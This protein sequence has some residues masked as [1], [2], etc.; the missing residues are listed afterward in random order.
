MSRVSTGPRTRM[1][2]TVLI[3]AYNEAD[4][5]DRGLAQVVEVLRTTL[6]D[7]AWEVVVVDDGSAD[8]TAQRARAAADALDGSDVAIRVVQHAV[9]RGLGGALQTGFATSTGDVVVVVDCDLSYHPMHIPLLVD[10]LE[11]TDAQIAV[12]SPYM[13]GGR[14]IGVPAQIERRSRIANAFLG[15]VSNSSI[16]T[17]TGMVRAY[18]GPF[19]RG[20][21]LRTMD[22]VLNVEALYKTGVL[23]GRVIE[24]PAVLDW[25]G[26]AD[27]SART[28]FG[29]KRTRSKTFHL[30]VSGLLFRPHIVFAALGTIAVVLG[31]AMGLLAALL[32]GSQVG[33]TVLGV[34]GMVTGVVTCLAAL[35]SVQ[36]KRSFEDLYHLQSSG[37]HLQSSAR[38]QV[39][40]SENVLS[41]TPVQIRVA[42][43][44]R[45]SSTTFSEHVRSGS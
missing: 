38:A 10:A 9:N 35:L 34:S 8:D 41:R 14:T 7:M 5:I 21:A 16:H 20:L 15:F 29:S 18:D 39:V 44:P 12:A 17:F 24:V 42:P 37:Y 1:T 26:L 36:V 31:G 40:T 32:P 33:L 11:E 22:D 45:S 4:T 43:T 27:R 2:G 30:V 19:V 13:P 23:R 25:S 6:A 3:P 28:R